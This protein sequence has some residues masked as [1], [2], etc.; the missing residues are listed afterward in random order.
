MAEKTLVVSGSR[1]ITDRKP[2][3]MAI[4]DADLCY[5]PFETVIHGGARG[6]DSSADDVARAKGWDVEVVEADWDTYGPA[7][8]P[9]RNARMAAR[10]DALAAVWDNESSG[11]KD[12][13]EKALGYGLDA[14]VRQP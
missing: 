14:V 1:S 2:V 4:E 7:A 13:I 3:K 8:G 12:M 5:G 6:V 9:K 10:A 11:T